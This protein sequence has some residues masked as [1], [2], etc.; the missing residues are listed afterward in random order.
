M[1]LT[2]SA[3]QFSMIRVESSLASQPTTEIKEATPM[4]MEKAARL[5]NF[6]F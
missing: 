5:L 6:M 4:A 3:L 1:N 2:G